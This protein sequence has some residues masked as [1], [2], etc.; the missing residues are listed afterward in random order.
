MTRFLVVLFASL[1][2]IPVFGQKSGSEYE[3]PLSEKFL[4]QGKFAE[5]ETASLLALDKDAADD[6]TRFGLGVIQVMRAVEKLGQSL[7]CLLYTSPSP[8]DRTR[9]RMPSSA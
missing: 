4:H 6:E 1:I 8:R 5:G 9:S 2:A 7:Y 3:V